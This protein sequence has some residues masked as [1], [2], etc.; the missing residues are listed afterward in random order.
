MNQSIFFIFPWF[1]ILDLMKDFK[2]QVATYT[3]ETKPIK[4][5]VNIRQTQT[6]QYF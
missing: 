6:N 5:N 4:Y 2:N 1:F 3:Y